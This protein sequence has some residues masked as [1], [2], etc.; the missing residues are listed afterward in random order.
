MMIQIASSQLESIQSI[1]LTDSAILLSGEEKPVSRFPRFIQIA[2]VPV[3]L[4]PIPV[5]VV[6]C[7]T[8]TPQFDHV[9]G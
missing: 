8:I 7:A 3:S 9:C 4:M 2:I 6:S 5:D 1:A